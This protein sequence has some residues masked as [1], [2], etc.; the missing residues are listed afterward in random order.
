MNLEDFNIERLGKEEVLKENWKVVIREVGGK[1]EVCV[2]M[3]I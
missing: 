3:E 1:L 2:I